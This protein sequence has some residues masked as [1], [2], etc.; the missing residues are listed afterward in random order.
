M[1]F[2]VLILNL[3]SPPGQLLWRDTAGGYGTSIPCLRKYQSSGES[4]LHPFLPY[5]SSLLKQAGIDFSILDCQRLKLNNDQILPIIKKINPDIILSII[6]LP[7]LA[8]DLKLLKKI[9]ENLIHVSI[10]CVGTVCRMLANEILTKSQFDI[11]LLRNSY[12]YVNGLTALIFALAD[13]QNLTDVYGVSTVNNGQIIH[14]PEPIEIDINNLPT[15]DYDSI[16]L[17][18]YDNY[19]DASGRKLPYTLILESKG[20]PY[21]CIYCPYPIGYGKQLTFRSATKIV[22]EIEHLNGHHG[23]KV[24]AFKGQTFAYNKKHAVEICDEILKRKLDII[25]FCESRVDEVGR[26]LLYKMSASGCKRIH[27]G[28]ETGDVENLKIAKPGISL[29]TTKKAFNLSRSYGFTTQAHVVLGW[30]DYNITRLEN[31]RKFLLELKPDVINLNFLT[32]Y[33][34]TKIRQV[35]LQNSLILTNDW[36]HYTSHTVVMKTKSLSANQLLY[37]K[38]KINRDFSLQKLEKHLL[39]FNYTN[40]LNP[41]TYLRKARMLAK[42]VLFPTID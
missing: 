29:E 24:F 16:P 37:Y 22:N 12:P 28:V 11:V 39:T 5:T 26:D 3:P 13:H 41:R 7:S 17:E 30:Q 40:I 34:G 4:P 15:P 9:K 20:C 2:R 25:W 35:A 1:A 31:T 38:R 6:S 14:C 33:P 19:S 23:V 42:R 8:N 36:S 21:G 10:V 18:G 32:P 27:F